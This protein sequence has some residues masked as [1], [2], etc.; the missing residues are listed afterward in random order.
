[1]RN[2]LRFLT[3]NSFIFLFV[4]LEVVA[5]GMLIQNNNYQNSK[6]FNSSNFLVGNLYATVNNFNDYFHLKEENQVLADQNARLQSTNVSSFMKVF[7]RLVQINDT[8]YLQNY[9][10][11][12]AK[13]I[14]NSTNKRQNYITLDKGGING[15]RPEMGVIS[16]KG[17]VGIVKNVSEHF[18]SVMSVL[19]EKNKLS[20]KI[21]KSG[22]FGS[23]VWGNN[24]YRIADLKDIPNHVNLAIGDTIVTSGFSSIFPENILIGTVK[25]FDLPEGN[26]FY[27]IKV[28]FSEDYKNISHVYIVRSLLKEE[29]ELLESKNLEGG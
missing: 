27:N 11:S 10:Y 28:E 20:A 16:S 2:L 8:T 19:H 24:D 1:M 26:N 23:L 13:V 4:V 29:K 12:S 5:F 14:N 9:V 7:G 21:K 22:Y 25:E 3:K 15:I 17:V 6:F 18:S